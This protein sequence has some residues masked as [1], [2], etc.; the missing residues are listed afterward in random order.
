MTRIISILT[1]F[2]TLSLS[3]AQEGEPTA[4]AR[5]AII[6]L[7]VRYGLNV[8]GAILI[9]VI[10][11][12]LAGFAARRVRKVAVD[13]PRIDTSLAGIMA[14]G[15]RIAILVLTVIAVLNRFGVQT[16]SMVA[17]LG[18]AGLAV[19]LALQGTLSNVAS[20]VILLSVRPF[21]VG[22]GVNIGDTFGVVTEIALFETRLRTFD[23]LAV[24]MPNSQVWSDKIINLSEND[25]RRVDL[26]FGIGYG[27]N[28]E[29]AFGII[30]EIIT[31]DERVLSEPAPLIAVDALG[32]NAVNII[33]RPWTATAD[34]FQTGL[35]LRK[36]VKE[37]FDEAGIS[38]P[39]PQRDL[40]IISGELAAQEPAS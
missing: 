15:T 33:A 11:W 14:Q 2:S 32:D 35:D 21:K 25:I 30:Q 5:S 12:W 23:G 26:V 39:F 29:Q 31:A 4:L 40:H 19:G 9:L 16:A 38:F 27:D 7:V 36:R 24:H 28:I 13:S 3:L 20:G 18:A 8:L 6:A 37:R 10:G 17:V 34:H 22:D 1:L